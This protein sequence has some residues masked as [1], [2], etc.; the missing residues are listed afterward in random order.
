MC[1]N[2]H[3]RGGRTTMKVILERNGYKLGINEN[4]DVSHLP[5]EDRYMI[6]QPDGE[7]FVGGI[8]GINRLFEKLSKWSGGCFQPPNL[9]TLFITHWILIRGFFSKSIKYYTIIYTIHV[10]HIIENNPLGDLSGIIRGLLLFHTAIDHSHHNVPHNWAIFRRT[11]I[12]HIVLCSPNY[13]RRLPAKFLRIQWGHWFHHLQPLSIEV[14][15]GTCFH[16]AE[17]IR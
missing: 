13:I 14:S 7:T 5:E 2:Y 12:G 15:L 8:K 4:P 6:E 17:I 11:S 3:L 1:S 16:N 9:T 10:K